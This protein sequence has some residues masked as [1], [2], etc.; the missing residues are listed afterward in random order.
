MSECYSC[1]AWDN[2]MIVSKQELRIQPKYEMA[3][4][5]EVEIYGPKIL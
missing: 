4:G 2:C 5:G 1:L 3:E